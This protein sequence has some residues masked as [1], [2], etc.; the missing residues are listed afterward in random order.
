MEM[1]RAGNAFLKM[2]SRSNV[3][4]RPCGDRGSFIYTKPRLGR[5][6]TFLPQSPKCQDVRVYH[7]ASQPSWLQIPYTAKEDLELLTL[8]L[9]SIVRGHAT[10]PVS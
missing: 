5:R 6:V 9:L 1:G 7:D 2:A 8:L 4:H 3:R 10:L